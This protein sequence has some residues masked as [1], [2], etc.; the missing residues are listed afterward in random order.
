MSN[1]SA[2]MKIDLAHPQH[3][4]SNQMLCILKNLQEKHAKW[5]IRSMEQSVLEAKVDLNPHQVEAAVFAF[6][7]PMNGGVILADEVGLGK[8]IEAGLI[9]SQLWSEDKKRILIIAPKSLRHQWQDELLNLFQISSSI[10]DTSD[11]KK[12]EA[13][14]NPLERNGQVVITNEHLVARCPHFAELISW[15][16]IIIDEAHKLA[17]VWRPGAK[18][19]KRAKAIRK[20]L[21]RHRKILL[22]ATPMQNNLMEL[23]G[24]IS[25]VDERI[26][27]TTESF[28]ATFNAATFES[29]PNRMAELRQRIGQALHRNLRS[30][31]SEYI[32][33][34]KRTTLTARFD[35]SVQ[36]DKFRLDFESF[37]RRG[38]VSLA[39]TDSALLKLLYLKLLAS[40]PNALKNTILG[41]I[42]RLLVVMAFE[43]D[44]ILFSQTWDKLSSKVASGIISE[45]ELENI[46]K[47]IFGDSLALTIAAAREELRENPPSWLDRIE[48]ESLSELTKDDSE[49]EFSIEKPEELALEKSALSTES[50]LV[51]NFLEMV[52]TI[53]STAKSNKLIETLKLQF[54]KAT[55]EGW[56]EKAV[57]FTE[58]RTTQ[59]FVLSCLIKEG[60]VPDKDIVI[61]N[62]DSGTADERRKKVEQ[63]RGSSKIFL[64]TEAG[65]EGLNLQ[66][67]NLV[68]NFDL[69]WNPQR[70][71]QRIGRCHRYG[72]KYD[73]VV[74]NFIN[75]KNP[76]EER[77]L[78][79]LQSKF[80]IFESAFGVSDQVIGAIASG[81]N[82]EKDIVEIYLSARS[83]E[84]IERSFKEVLK[85]NKSLI[86]EKMAKAWEALSVQF[87]E[88]VRK[89]LKNTNEQISKEISVNQDRLKGVV[90]Q[91]L[92]SNKIPFREMNGLMKIE[93]SQLHHG[94]AGEYTFE[95]GLQKDYELIHPKH[96]LVSRIETELEIAPHIKIEA[97]GQLINGFTLKA[98][99]IG[100]I[101]IKRIRSVGVDEKCEFCTYG[102]LRD[103]GKQI[104]LNSKQC[105]S[106]LNLS[107]SEATFQQG[108]FFE[109]PTEFFSQRISA[110]KAE[111][112]ARSQSIFFEEEAKYEAYMKDL[113]REARVEREKI[114]REINE[115][116]AKFLNLPLDQQMVLQTDLQKL[117]DK[118]LQ[119]DENLLSTLKEA[120]LQEKLHS[121][122]VSNGMKMDVIAEAIA[123]FTFEIA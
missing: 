98:G 41:L 67:C 76:A 81:S 40:S 44:E 114:Q 88:D 38:G 47:E 118:Q 61:F 106:L 65:A 26:L 55:R 27:G 105:D 103:D 66:F 110:L 92:T 20:A 79:L 4:T 68:I 72:Q 57:I 25:F 45:I 120:R 19:S 18:D 80:E 13:G 64:T 59:N 116:R 91:W 84:E 30:N 11:L 96:P 63:F 53:G 122:K 78:D 22:T 109:E 33:Y 12:C 87:N 119:V 111:H 100:K 1:S 99:A 3:L 2:A 9:L 52:S 62:G 123:E 6:R 5:D 108:E 93:D 28:N 21:A 102:L 17:N 107:G 35:P 46:Q 48:S 71:E 58:F 89:K 37:L 8:T 43:S 104:I 29:D 10:I 113:E 112:G 31:V 69:P 70:I 14:V 32:N 60:F 77:I 97:A 24:L 101:W 94:L 23:F 121:Q 54:S 42:R 34:K 117:K 50:D 86:D 115:L 73:V 15:D 83:P 7:N 95:K 90:A 82:F 49:E 75:S 56:P 39:A 16:C 85:K 36:E 51:F 74:V